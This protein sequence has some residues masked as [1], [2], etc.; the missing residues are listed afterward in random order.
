MYIVA[1]GPILAP[2][3]IPVSSEETWPPT[4]VVFHSLNQMASKKPG[5]SAVFVRTKTPI[6]L[7]TATAQNGQRVQ[8][9]EPSL[10]S[11]N[12]NTFG[13]ESSKKHGGKLPLMAT[14]ISLAQC[15]LIRE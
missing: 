3:T 11:P 4:I 13:S 2:S 10:P 9:S 15:R 7:V 12:M 6:P 8:P 5:I 14:R 1:L